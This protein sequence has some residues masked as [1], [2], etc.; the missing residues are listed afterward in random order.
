MPAFNFVGIVAFGCFVFKAGYTRWEP[1]FYTLHLLTFIASW[2]MFVEPRTARR[3]AY[4]GTAGLLAAFAFLAKA[5]N[6][7]FAVLLVAVGA[8]QALIVLARHRQAGAALVRR[9]WQSSSV[10]CF[11]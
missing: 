7:P 2:Q 5:A 3:F 8:G 4:A 9:R 10:S 1:L 6:L 11:S